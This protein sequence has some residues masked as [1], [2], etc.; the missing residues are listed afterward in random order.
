[1]HAR[2]VQTWRTGKPC[3]RNIE[4]LTF[5]V[6]SPEWPWYNIS[7][8][9]LVGSKPGQKGMEDR[10]LPM[11]HAPPLHGAS[12]SKGTAGCYI[13]ALTPSQDRCQDQ[14]VYNAWKCLRISNSRFFSGFT[15]IAFAFP[16]ATTRLLKKDTPIHIPLISKNIP[17][18][19][20]TF[21][22][23]IPYRFS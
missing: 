14:V 21:P 2:I 5:G 6:S 20:P 16:K 7:D 9:A 1:M 4:P 3:C 12:V 13:L 8:W 15:L 11:Q 19:I 22:Y 23:N 10:M 18:H 17:K